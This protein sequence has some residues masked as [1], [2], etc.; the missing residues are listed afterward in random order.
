MYKVHSLNK[1]YACKL[2]SIK[3]SYINEFKIHRILGK[4]PN[5]VEFIDSFIWVQTKVDD[6]ISSNEKDS[7]VKP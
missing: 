6:S 2:V 1:E 4:H 5:I 3:T 7:K